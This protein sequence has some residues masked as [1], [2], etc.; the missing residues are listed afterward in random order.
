[1]QDCNISI[2]N[3]L[4]L[5]QY[6]TKPWIWWS[7]HRC[8]YD[9][10]IFF[11]EKINRP[12][13]EHFSVLTYHANFTAHLID[14]DKFWLFKRHLI[15]SFLVKW[16]SRSAKIYV[17][18]LTSMSRI[19]LSCSEEYWVHCFSALEFLSLYTLLWFY[20]RAAILYLGS[21]LAEASLLWTVGAAEKSIVKVFLLTTLTLWSRRNKIAIILQRHFQ[22]RCLEWQ[23]FSSID[24]C[25]G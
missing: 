1:M 17:Y 19:P 24:N 2:A 3:A 12:L 9:M 5:L 21:T 15:F 16:F 23:P 18:A 8:I 20:V 7:N 4:E 22:L 14:K 6:F 11:R 10:R 25:F 13:I